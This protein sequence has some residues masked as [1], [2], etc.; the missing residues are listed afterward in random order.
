MLP[1]SKDTWVLSPQETSNGDLTV[2]LRPQALNEN[3]EQKEI[4]RLC[5]IGL[6]LADF[7]EKKCR[8]IFPL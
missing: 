6:Q 1:L 5:C 8:D 4:D 7:M 2:Y 3:R